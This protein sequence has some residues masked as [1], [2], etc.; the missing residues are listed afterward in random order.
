MQ[1]QREPSLAELALKADDLAGLPGVSGSALRKS[2]PTSADDLS[3]PLNTKNDLGP[4]TTVRAFLFKYEEAY[5]VEAGA[6]DGQYATYIGNYLYRYA[7]SA[8][9]E[10]AANELIKFVLQDPQ[11]KPLDI[12]PQM[13][14]SGTRGQTAMTIDLE[15]SAIYWFAAAKGRTLILLMVNGMPVPPTQEAFEALAIRI[16][17]K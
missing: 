14:D 15:G 13:T 1:A 8:Q 17:Q 9:A 16:L 3:Q 12:G 2:G 5:A 11:G 6:W 4:L 10:A 7:D